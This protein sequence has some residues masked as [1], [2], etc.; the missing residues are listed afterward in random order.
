M[1]EGTYYQCSMCEY[2][3]Y[4]LQEGRSFVE[5]YHTY[6]NGSQTFEGYVCYGCLPDPVTEYFDRELRGE[7]HPEGIRRERPRRREPLPPADEN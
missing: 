3:R 4:A 6:D 7:P 5:K 2:G 1:P